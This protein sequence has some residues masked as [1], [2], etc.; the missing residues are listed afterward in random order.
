MLGNDMNV[1]SLIADDDVGDE[2]NENDENRSEKSPT[3]VSFLKT[4]FIL[5]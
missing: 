3:A 4:Y 1:R 2:S 5:K